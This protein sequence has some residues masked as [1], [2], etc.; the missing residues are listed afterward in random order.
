M[1]DSPSF[2]LRFEQSK[3]VVFTDGALHVTND[4]PSGIVHELYTDLSD[5]SAR[6]CPPKDLYKIESLV[7]QI[8]FH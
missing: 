7:S 2:T 6:S 8:S 4:R 3:N 1:W 5:T